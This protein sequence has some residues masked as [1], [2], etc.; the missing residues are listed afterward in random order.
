MVAD[1]AAWGFV[2]SDGCG[3]LSPALAARV[4]RALGLDHTPAAYQVRL[5][6]AKG[7][8]V[9]D[10]RLGSGR[11]ELVQLRPSMVKFASNTAHNVLEV[12]GWSAPQ[13]AHLNRQFIVLLEARGVPLQVS[14]PPLS[15][16]C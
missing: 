4:A 11:E 13:R 1:V 10:P 3:A 7:M 14:D 15:P 2:F 8:L 16:P 9:V 6:G 12:C 5:L